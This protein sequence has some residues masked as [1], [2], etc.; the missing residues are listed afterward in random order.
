LQNDWSEIELCEEL[1]RR[2]LIL[3]WMLKKNIRSYTE[4]GEIVNLYSK[5]PEQIFKKAMEEMKK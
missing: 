5:Y 1:E 2:M 4:V 3:N